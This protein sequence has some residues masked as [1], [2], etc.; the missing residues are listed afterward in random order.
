MAHPVNKIPERAPRTDLTV[1]DNDGDVRTAGHSELVTEH[2]RTIIHNDVVAKIAG[3]SVRRVEGVHA[4]V[5]YGTGQSVSA[6]A[7][8]ITG[9]VMR[10]LGVQVEVGK[11]QAAV[12]VRIVTEYGTGIVDIANKIRADVRRNIEHM[13]GLEVVEVNIEVVDLFFSEDGH[14]SAGKTSTRVQ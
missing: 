9:A 5:P 6:F 7:R 11:I 1:V 14:D 4:L 12:D 13:T 3:V 2:G 8:R 10:D